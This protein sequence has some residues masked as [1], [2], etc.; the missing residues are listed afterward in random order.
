M[1]VV[2]KAFDDVKEFLKSVVPPCT[3]TIDDNYHY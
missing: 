2:N 1:E 3:T